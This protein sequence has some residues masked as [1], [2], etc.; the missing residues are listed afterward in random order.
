MGPDTEHWPGRRGPKLCDFDLCNIAE[1]PPLS[2][3][4]NLKPVGHKGYSNSGTWMFMASEL[5]TIPA[6]AGKVKRVYRHE[7][8]AFMNVLLWIICQYAN[9]GLVED[10]PLKFWNQRDYTHIRL[11][12]HDTDAKILEGTFPK[13]VS[14]SKEL[15]E[16]VATSISR[17][18]IFLCRAQVAEKEHKLYKQK[19]I[20]EPEDASDYEPE[21][22]LEDYDGLRALLKVFSWPIFKHTR[23]K[24]FVRLTK[25]RIGL[26]AR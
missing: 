15:W 8:E 21:E 20:D 9:G 26:S 5:L 6:M 10:S 2:I 23:A 19:L 7:L 25:A 16:D 18:G 1:V 24:P 13:P 12:R 22:P 17:F 14:L 11:Q 3:E 4:A